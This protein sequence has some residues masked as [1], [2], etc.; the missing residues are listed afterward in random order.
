[1]YYAQ[2]QAELIKRE[3]YKNPSDCGRYIIDTKVSITSFSPIRPHR[4]EK[5]YE[6]GAVRKKAVE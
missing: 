5:Q 1:M 2:A 4:I 3:I 6:C